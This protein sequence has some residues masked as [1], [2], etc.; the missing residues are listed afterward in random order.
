MMLFW[1]ISALDLESIN[2]KFYFTRSTCWGLFF[3][4][5]LFLIV[6]VMVVVDFLAL[7]ER[8]K[9]FEDYVRNLSHPSPSLFI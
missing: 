1:Q 2:V 5:F 7:L 3:I 9:V 6:C 4:I 8:S